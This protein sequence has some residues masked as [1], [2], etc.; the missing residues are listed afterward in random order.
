MRARV[1][2]AQFLSE[3]N[4]RLKKSLKP[5]G[6]RSQPSANGAGSQAGPFLTVYQPLTNPQGPAAFSTVELGW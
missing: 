1:R 4:S 3:W 5:P 2:S 6:A